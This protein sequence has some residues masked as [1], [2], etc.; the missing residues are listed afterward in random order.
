MKGK[1]LEI[2]SIVWGNGVQSEGQRMK[3]PK[4]KAYVSLILF[5]QRV[6]KKTNDGHYR[7]FVKMLQK[8]QVTMHF[9]E[10]IAN[11]LSYT[12]Y[13][14][15]IVSNKKKLEDFVMVSLIEA[16]SVEENISI[17][18]ILDRGYIWLLEGR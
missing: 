6:N 13:L 16:S 1:E 4:V 10:V 11:T 9:F 7:K 8:L 15:E 3:M 2:W 5:P 17:P 18:I 12:M 14:N